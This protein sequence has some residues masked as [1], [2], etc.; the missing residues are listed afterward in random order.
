MWQYIYSFSSVY[1]TWIHTTVSY[2][3]YS[4]ILCQTMKLET[5]I[6]EYLPHFHVNISQLS[7]CELRSLMILLCYIFYWLDKALI[8]DRNNMKLLSHTLIY[9]CLEWILPFF[10]SFLCVFVCF[11]F[12]FL[13]YSFLS[14]SSLSLA[15]TC[16]RD[17]RYSN[18]ASSFKS[19]RMT[20]GGQCTRF[21]YLFNVCNI[22]AQ[23]MKS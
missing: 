2:A 1:W 4:L 14:V 15:V 20:F 3:R 5:W 19:K 7:K 22:E 16:E 10:H 17:T 18:V 6:H 9:I 21:F 23:K 13:C 8:V 12:F 11:L